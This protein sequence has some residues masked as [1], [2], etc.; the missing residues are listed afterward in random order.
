MI[1]SLYALKKVALMRFKAVRLIQ[2]YSFLP[3]FL[4]LFFPPFFPLS[5]LHF[6][7]FIPFTYLLSACC[8]HSD[9]FISCNE[10]SEKRHEYEP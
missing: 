5:I 9:F 3:F 10:A 8:G 1:S 4:S 2:L 7:S 6:Y